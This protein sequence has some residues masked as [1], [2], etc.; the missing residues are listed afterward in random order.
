VSPHDFPPP[1]GWR[2]HGFRVAMPGKRVFGS[3]VSQT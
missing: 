3:Y 2:V 1:S